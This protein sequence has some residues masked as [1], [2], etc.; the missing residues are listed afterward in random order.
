MKL[1]LVSSEFPPG[2]GGIG[3]H[4]YNLSNVLAE[5]GWEVDVVTELRKQFIANDGE[6]SSNPHID[7]IA[8]DSN[9]RYLKFIG[10]CI[11]ACY[12]KNNLIIGSGTRSVQ[13][14]G[15]LNL[16]AARPMIAILHG[17]ETIMGRGFSKFLTRLALRGF[18]RAIAVS[19][20][21]K[22]IASK[23][24]QESKIGVIPNGINPTK[25]GP[26]EDHK[27]NSK[28]STL[29]L[30]TVGRL[31]KRKGQHNMIAALPL[32]ASRHPQLTYHLVGLD[33]EKD[34]LVR[35][36]EE[37]GVLDRIEFHGVLSDGELRSVLLRSD[38]SIM[39]S[40]NLANGDVEGFGIAVIEAN[41]FG[42]PSIGAKGCG[43]EQA[44]KHGY[45]GLLVD[46]FN[47]HEVAE[48][49]ESILSNYEGFSINATNWASAHYW[50][51]IGVCYLEEI[52]SL[53]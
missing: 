31:S 27:R 22:G 45:N 5:A 24:M 9:F 42:V 46:P 11:R 53:C 34:Y 15:I 18:S 49:I 19:E 32:I 47:V 50:G 20:F 8:D 23:A 3:D 40:E 1:V 7:Y 36:A 30:I 12:S 25:F 39:L 29:Q 52:K 44:I 16:L 37:L 38:I 2:P 26:I 4:A 14:L 13:V 17:H 41:Y 48:A 33:S 51:R 28:P 10:A 43:L 6:I 21:S 35:Q